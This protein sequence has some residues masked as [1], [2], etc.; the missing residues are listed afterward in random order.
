MEARMYQALN[1]LQ[2]DIKRDD[3]NIF[4]A[5]VNALAD[6]AKIGITERKR[7]LFNCLKPGFDPTGQFR[8]L[9]C[10]PQE[11]YENFV[12]ALTAAVVDRTEGYEHRQ[13]SKD[14]QRDSSPPLRRKSERHGRRATTPNISKPAV[15]IKKLVNLT[16]EEALINGICFGCGTKGHRR[17]E[18]P[19]TQHVIQAFCRTRLEDPV[20]AQD[21]S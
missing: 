17:A 18:C 4:I 8:R 14:D 20:D 12:D 13:K 7:T 21:P 9:V 16:R 19:N 6:K 5:K 11:S 3:I 1:R 10:N 15:D 2:F